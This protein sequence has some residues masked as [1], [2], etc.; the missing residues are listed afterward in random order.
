MSDLQPKSDPLLDHDYDGI[1]EYDN[2]MPG[3]WQALFW[4]SIAFAI[5]YSV[6][7]HGGGGGKSVH[8]EYEEEVAAAHE[9]ELKNAPPLLTET[10]LAAA[11]ADPAIVSAGAAK[12]KEVCI[13]C[14]GEKAEGKIGPNLTDKYWLH[15]KGNLADIYQTIAKGVPE[16]GMPTWARNLK[17]D[18]LKNVAA[19]VGSLRNT[20]VAGKAPQGEPVETAAVA[21]PTPAPT[22]PP[23]PVPMPALVPTPT[24][25]TAAT[26]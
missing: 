11:V 7:L 17:P 4:L 6:W 21:A 14:H 2:P 10:E 19:F 8:A 5:A 26:P 25:P 23:A 9:L 13:A 20:N 22:V 18:E 16:K 3:W 15:G 12:F 1:R 24:E